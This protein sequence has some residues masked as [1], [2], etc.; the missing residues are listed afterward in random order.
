M[1]L[2]LD[3]AKLSRK[4]HGWTVAFRPSYVRGFSWCRGR[5]TSIEASAFISSHNRTIIPC[6]LDDCWNHFPQPPALIPQ[7]NAAIEALVLSS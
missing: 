4:L 3:L 6:S 7:L 1:G 5:L 2:H